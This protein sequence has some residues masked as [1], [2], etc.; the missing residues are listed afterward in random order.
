MTIPAVNRTTAA[1]PRRPVAAATPKPA[2]PAAAPAVRAKAQAPKAARPEKFSDLEAYKAHVLS[3]EAAKLPAA[4]GSVAAAEADLARAN[5]A[6]AAKQ[7][8]VNHAGLKA[9]LDKTETA[10][11]T[12]T[13]PHRPQAAAKRAEADKVS[14]QAGDLARQIASYQQQLARAEGRQAARNRDFWWGDN[15]NRSGWDDLFDGLGAIGDASTISSA[16]RKVNT[17]I[18][19]KVQL[20]MKAATLVA[21][22]AA[23]H[24]LKADP[25]AIVSQTKARDEAKAAFDGAVALEAPEQKVVDAAQHSLNGAKGELARLEGVKKDL[26]DYAKQFGF[27]ARVKLFFTDWAWKKDLDAFWKSKGL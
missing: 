20:D 27:F 18:D 14:G 17:L 23:L 8:E 2:A 5:L 13:F 19:Q 22:A 12:A 4:R 15:S 26:T 16:K 10:L 1:A 3:S 25:G 11:E 24:M 21:E 7:R 6:L 9:A